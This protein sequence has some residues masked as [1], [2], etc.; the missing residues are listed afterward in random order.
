VSIIESASSKSSDFKIFFKNIFLLPKT[1]AIEIIPL[2]N[3]AL[4]D[5]S[6][7]TK[8]DRWM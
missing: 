7:E 6:G 5:F 4:I 2:T 3:M 1:F 8:S